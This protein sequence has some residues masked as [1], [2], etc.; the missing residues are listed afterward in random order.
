[1]TESDNRDRREAGDRRTD[2]G[3][4]HCGRQRHQARQMDCGHGPS[5]CPRIAKQLCA[6][7]VPA[8]RHRTATYTKA[9]LLP[10]QQNT[11]PTYTVIKQQLSS[12]RERA[13]SG[14]VV[15]YGGEQ[16]EAGQLNA[17]QPQAEASRRPNAQPVTTQQCVY[18]C[19]LARC[20]CAYS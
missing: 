15:R 20:T 17:R 1:M 13:I 18:V 14:V 6:V 5:T 7:R 2:A 9:Y 4:E 11:T 12:E 10:Q 19:A 3:A 8:I 16:W